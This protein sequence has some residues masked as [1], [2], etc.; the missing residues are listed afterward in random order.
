MAVFGLSL[1]GL[2]LASVLFQAAAV[3]VT[4]L[5]AR[6]F[7]GGRLAQVAAALAVALSPLPIFEATEFQYSSFDYLWWVLAEY[8]V[9]RLIN[10]EDGRW[11]LGIGACIGMGLETKYTMAFFAVGLVG[12]LVLTRERKW[13]GS[14]W[15]WM[16]VAIT[17]V[18]FAPNL[19][20][21]ARHDWVSLKFLQHIHARDVRQGR[22]NG[23]LLQ[24]L[25]LCVSPV[26]AVLWLRGLWWCFREARW[27]MLGWMYAIP[28]AR[29]VAGEGR[30]YYFAAIYPMLIAAGAVQWWPRDVAVRRWGWRIWVAALAA[31]G[32][33]FVGLLVPVLPVK[34]WGTW[35]MRRDGAPKG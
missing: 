25:W 5:M 21:Q 17:L 29:F 26:A 19:L 11:W 33:F 8:C 13:L 14:K 31:L 27:R 9:V 12:A 28:L 24:Q 22:A 2:R 15:L 32:V 4:G 18:M 34:Q 16:G 7:G 10:S 1:I 23:F 3:F 6:E 20:W 30:G 35:A